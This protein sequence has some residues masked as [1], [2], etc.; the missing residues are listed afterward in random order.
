LPAKKLEGKENKE[1]Q[2]N[3]KN[4]PA[5]SEAKKGGQNVKN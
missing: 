2:S 1:A 4:D 5:N 3:L